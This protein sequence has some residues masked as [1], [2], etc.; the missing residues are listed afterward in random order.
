MDLGSR[1]QW[2][3]SI[4]SPDLLQLFPHLTHSLLLP[5]G[6]TMEVVVTM[7]LEMVP[8]GRESNPRDLTE[9]ELTGDQKSAQLVYSFSKERSND[10]GYW[11]CGLHRQRD[12]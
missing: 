10:S 5:R 11:R 6:L 8:K 1:R 2:D 4:I 3:L 7:R 12:G 9:E